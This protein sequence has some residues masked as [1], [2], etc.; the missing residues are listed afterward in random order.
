MKDNK[1]LVSACAALGAWA[2]GGLA[3]GSAAAAAAAAGGPSA[4]EIAS[5]NEPVEPFRIHGNTYYVG[6]KNLSSVLITSDF[7]HVLI[8]A[9][10]PESAP[11]IAA[12]IEKLGFRVEDVKAILSSHAHPDHVGGIAELQKRARFVRNTNAGLSESHVHDVSITREAPNY[13]TR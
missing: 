9:G 1:I 7:G 13:P 3:A 11:L 12:S 6:T 10:L 5:W 8:D 2:L 4:A